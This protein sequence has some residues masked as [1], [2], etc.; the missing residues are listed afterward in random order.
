[1]SLHEHIHFVDKHTFHST[2][3][4]NYTKE[5]P[6]VN[7]GFE[8]DACAYEGTDDALGAWV[9]VQGRIGNPITGISRAAFGE[10]S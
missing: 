1:M 9:I 10:F 5:C 3:I 8:N 6:A 4:V 2:P 7:C